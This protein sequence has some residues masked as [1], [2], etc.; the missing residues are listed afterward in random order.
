MYRNMDVLHSIT[1]SD[2]NFICL[3]SLTLLIALAILTRIVSS[4]WSCRRR[5]TIRSST[6]SPSF[7]LCASSISSIHFSILPLSFAAASPSSTIASTMAFN[8]AI[9][10]LYFAEDFNKD[11]TRASSGAGSPLPSVRA[12]D[13]LGA[14]TTFASLGPLIVAAC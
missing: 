4:S 3:I 9:E 8:F 11:A 2:F 14:C 1:A 7:S 10:I 13:T 6:I 5:I 12:A